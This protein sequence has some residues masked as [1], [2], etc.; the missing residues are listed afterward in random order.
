MVERFGRENRIALVADPD[1][2]YLLVLPVDG[3]DIAAMDR[4]AELIAERTNAPFTLAAFAVDS[5]N[6]DLSP[7]TA[8]PVFGKEA[9]GSGAPQTLA[10]IE[11]QLVP[12]VI[13]RCG[14]SADIPVILGGYSLAGLFALWSAYRTAGFAAIAAVSPSVWFPG[15]ID[16]AAGREPMAQ[17]IYLSL[18]DR[19]EKAKNPVMARVG[20]CIRRQHSLLDGRGIDTVLE[21]NPGNHFTDPEKRLAKAFAWCIG[22]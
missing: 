21:W 13:D 14:L 7:W 17:C 11:K 10:F 16:F 12:G 15:W 8:P 4:Q 20:E 18:G 2:E 6:D 5:W 3:R 19:E 22:A 1:A 9:F